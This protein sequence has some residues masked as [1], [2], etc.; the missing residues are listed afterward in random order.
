ML[1]Y[2]T[3]RRFDDTITRIEA[4]IDSLT[5]AVAAITQKGDAMSVQLDNLK[6]AVQRNSDLEASAVQLIQGLATQLEAIKDDPVAIQA[7]ADELKA[8]DD[9]LAAAITQN[10]PPAP[11]GPTGPTP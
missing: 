5:A 1:D 10:T 11:T 7:L 8:K 2:G 6:A 4:K 3:I 9:D